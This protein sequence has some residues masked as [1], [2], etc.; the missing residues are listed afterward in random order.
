VAVL[1]GDG[2]WTSWSG[3]IQLI[4]VDRTS[5]RPS[6]WIQSTIWE[7]VWGGLLLSGWDRTCVACLLCPKGCFENI[8]HQLIYDL[9]IPDDWW[10]V[11]NWY[12][13]MNGEFGGDYRAR[14][15]SSPMNTSPLI[16]NSNDCCAEY[17]RKKGLKSG[18][19]VVM[20][21]L[22]PHLWIQSVMSSALLPP[23]L[24]W[25]RSFFCTQSSFEPHIKNWR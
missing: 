11:V 24:H 14:N 4:L 6:H 7:F 8:S 18:C 21:W 12:E 3:L 2:S 16:W 10:E 17:P 9:M 22:L 23:G 25:L 13:L 20:M 5:L 19:V 1:S 15:R